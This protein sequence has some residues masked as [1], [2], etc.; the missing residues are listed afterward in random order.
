MDNA[1]SIWQ[2]TAELPEFPTLAGDISTDVLVIGGGMAGLLTAYR[3]QQRGIDVVVAEKDRLCTGTTAHTTAKVTA[4][5]GLC[6]QKLL[7]GLGETSARMYYEANAGAVQ[8]LKALC[9]QADCPMEEKDNFVYS[10]DPHRIEGELTALQRLGIPAKHALSPP[11]PIRAEAVGFSGQAQIH[12]LK[13]ARFLAEKLTVYEQTWV[14]SLDGTTAVTDTGRIHAR[15]VVVATHFPFV[16]RR[17]SYFL[18][19]Y[20]HRSYLLALENAPTLPGMYVD[21]SP[22]GMT[23]SSFGDHLLLGGGGHR[24]GKPGG[25]WAQLRDFQA[26][27]YPDSREVCRWAAQD[28]M[29]LDA[30]PYIGHYSRNT[31]QLYVAAG[32]NKWGMTGSMVSAEVLSAMLA[33]EEP[34]Y[35]PLFSPSRSILKPQLVVNGFSSAANLLTFRTP[36]CPHMGCALHYNRA[37]HSWDCPCHGS[38]FS[39]SGRVLDNPAN[40]NRQ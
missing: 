30:I 15:R 37:E 25:G 36:R 10:A 20:Q 31:P 26:A 17:G 29:S 19:L 27:H 32:F 8:Q 28:T 40:R 12:P 38:R 5:H 21:D 35:A 18:K 14:R 6:Y 9:R 16:N 22:T 33:G 13:L 2:K 3:L 1:R 4:Q 39:E 11:I 34:E 23:F 24:T 7:Q